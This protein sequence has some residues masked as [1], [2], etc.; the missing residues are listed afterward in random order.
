LHKND[1]VRWGEYVTAMQY[2]YVYFQDISR[3]W[4]GRAGENTS[5]R[6]VLWPIPSS[7]ITT[8]NLMTQNTG[9]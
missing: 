3:L 6:D 7:E 2:S 4:L 1:L 5:A 9:W 8:N